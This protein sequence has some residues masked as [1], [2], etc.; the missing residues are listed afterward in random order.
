MMF[1]TR[2]VFDYLRCRHCGSLSIETI[3]TD[4]ARHYPP[5]YYQN[6]AP[7][8]STS[9]AIERA[10]IRV[11]VA[12][13]AFGSRSPLLGIARRIAEIPSEY[14]RVRDFVTGGGLTS[15]DDPIID[16]GCG[17]APVRL[18]MLQK[19]GFRN[20]VGVEPFID[21]GGTFLGVPVR[22][23]RLRDMPGSFRLI[24]FHHSLEHVPDPLST[25]QDAR[26]RIQPL[27][28]CLVRTPIIGGHFWRR[29]GVNWVELDAPRHLT[30]FSLQGL[31]DLAAR[32]GFEISSVTFESAAWEFIASEQY[33]RD[34]AMYEP[35]SWFEDPAASGVTESTLSE[36]Q[37]AAGRLNSAEDA[38]RAAIWLRPIADGQWPGVR[39]DA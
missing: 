9:S 20:V 16:V 26:A 25:L 34:V 39:T 3:P 8:I 7:P 32:A 35:R 27:G 2:E 12:E 21:S 28:R 13:R 30:V 38:G 14:R 1:G 17:A 11:L 33:E 23:G 19:V 31:T 4:L 10:A 24:M 18:A 29:Y 15:F 36:F 5:R 37:A 6:N 22:K